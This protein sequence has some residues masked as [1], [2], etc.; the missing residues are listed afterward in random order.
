MMFVRTKNVNDIEHLVFVNSKN[1]VNL[2]SHL[3]L[4]VTYYTINKLRI[5]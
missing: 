4:R 2:Y 5:I 1:I 3:L